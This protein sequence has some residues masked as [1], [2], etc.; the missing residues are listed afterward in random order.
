MKTGIGSFLRIIVYPFR[1]SLLQSCHN[2][3]WIWRRTRELPSVFAIPITLCSHT[4][5]IFF[6][7]LS[8]LWLQKILCTPNNLSS[9]LFLGTALQLNDLEPTHQFH[10]CFL[11][12]WDQELFETLF[13][14]MRQCD[15][16]HGACIEFRFLILYI[17]EHVAALSPLKSFN[18]PII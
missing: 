4:K 16:I 6:Y 1:F 11:D 3:H 18:V 5:I 15:I 12:A 10:R 14:W 9:L 2:A 13:V 17:P 7:Y 8:C